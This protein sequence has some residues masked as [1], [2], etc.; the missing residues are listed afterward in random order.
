MIQ[1]NFL[2]LL[3][4]II[5][6]IIGINFLY[7]QIKPNFEVKG[8]NISSVSINEVEKQTVVYK[9]K[10]LEINKANQ[11]I[12]KNKLTLKQIQTQK[13]ELEKELLNLNIENTALQR[14]YLENNESLK[15][16]TSIGKN[17]NNLLPDQKTTFEKKDKEI[18]EKI[19][20][21]I[22]AT[23]SVTI[24]INQKVI[25]EEAGLNYIKSLENT[26]DS[27]KNEL[28]GQL[29]N[30]INIGLLLA[31]NYAIYLFILLIIWLL[32]KFA[33]R[34]IYKDIHNETI[35]TAS[36]KTVKI[37]WITISII[38]IFYAFAGQFSYILASFG[39]VSAALVFALQ[40]FVASFFVFVI[41]SFTKII[42][43]GDIV[44]I[45]PVGE[46]YTGEVL[47]IGRFYTFIKEINPENQEELGRT[48]SI[49]NSFLLLHPVTNFTV[50][51][52]IIWQTLKVVVNGNSNQTTTK[53]ILRKI[54]I[55]KFEWVKNEQAQYLG[56]S[57]NIEELS[58]KL[59]MSLEE[60][61]VAYTMHFPCHFKKY[62]EVYDQ[63]LTEV[64]DEFK[65]SDIK[66]A[67]LP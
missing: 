44:K 4:A 64:I 63:L 62:N 36:R 8:S 57:V 37:I 9:E 35:K 41:I 13:L 29:I 52:K 47:D 24:K 54:L 33:L 66:I 46:G 55:Q 22:E 28:I 1:K 61:G 26:L 53:K 10:Q 7:A 34:V 67:F 20:I 65:S 12:D 30:V 6:C 60:R 14:Q 25:E 2:T 32:Y 40:G 51:N 50:T 15:S 39:F 18:V 23:D 56:E 43:K 19:R 58:P 5:T 27:K 31:S 16:L 11:E 59:S 48:V 38:V 21:N 49:P 3:V 45:G 42:K 17:I